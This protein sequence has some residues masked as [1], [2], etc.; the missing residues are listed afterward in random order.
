MLTSK[1]RS[2]SENRANQRNQGN[3]LLCCNMCDDYQEKTISIYFYNWRKYLFSM[4]F[5]SKCISVYCD[6]Y[7]EILKRNESDK[8]TCTF[9]FV[10]INNFLGI[11]YIIMCLVCC[12]I[13]ML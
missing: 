2:T 8:N 7:N 4:Y 9:C 11:Q 3:F 5:L 13:E 12:G 10:D 1:E 6:R